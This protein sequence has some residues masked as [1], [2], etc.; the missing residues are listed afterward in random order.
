MLK[1]REECDTYLTHV[2]RYH[3]SRRSPWKEENMSFQ[4]TLWLSS[5]VAFSA[6]VMSTDESQIGV[7]LFP[8]FNISYLS[9]FSF[10]INWLV[11]ISMGAISYR[12]NLHL[13]QHFEWIN[14]FI[15]SQ[16]LYVSD[17][18]ILVIWLTVKCI[19]ISE[20]NGHWTTCAEQFK[21]F[22]KPNKTITYYTQEDFCYFQKILVCYIGKYKS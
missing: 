8:S 14:S 21:L 5:A 13:T 6:T 10:Y 17:L 11:W 15:H 9:R 3:S 20:N 12:R 7:A 22:K 18:L 4:S 16:T 1:R 2:S 19:K